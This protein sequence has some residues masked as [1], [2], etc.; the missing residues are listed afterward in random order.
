M[1]NIN[2]LYSLDKKKEKIKKKTYDYVLKLSHNK[3]KA[4]AKNGDRFCWFQT[5]EVV[6]GLP[7]YDHTDVTLHVKKKLIENGFKVE[8]YDPNVLM[9]SW[10]KNDK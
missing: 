3:I 8:Y 9:I 4:V 6:I 7:N 2:D 1:I 10:E 5:P